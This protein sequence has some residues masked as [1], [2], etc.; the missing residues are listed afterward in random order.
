MTVYHLD[1]AQSDLDRLEVMVPYSALSRAV[2]LVT[3][4]PTWNHGRVHVG[5]LTDPQERRFDGLAARNR[6]L[7]PRQGGPWLVVAHELA[8]VAHWNARRIDHGEGWRIEFSRIAQLMIS[9]GV[10]CTH[11]TSAPHAAGR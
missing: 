8:H 9:L 3:A 6:V 4:D 5:V 1:V 2:G 7:F 10:V 11:G